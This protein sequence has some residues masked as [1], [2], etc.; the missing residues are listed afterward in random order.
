MPERTNADLVK[1]VLL[2]DYDAEEN[3][4]LGAAIAAATI[5][6]DDIK[7]KSLKLA[8]LISDDRLE[9]IERWL[10]AHFYAV[11]DRPYSSRSTGGGSGSFDGSTDKG[12]DFTGY[13]QHARLLDPTGYLASLGGT[14]SGGGEGA[15]R[16]KVG[17]FWA[18]RA[19]SE[20]L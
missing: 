15:V 17:G 13:G 14:A 10:A 11:S 6:V 18:G 7:D 19:P 8:M 20:R 5:L 4:D 9:I 3:P 16:P 2:N 1:A 12:L